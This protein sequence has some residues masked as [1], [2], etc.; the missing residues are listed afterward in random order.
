ML[1]LRQIMTHLSVMSAPQASAKTLM[2]KRQ[3]ILRK[4]QEDEN[5]AD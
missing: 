1:L 2:Q 4:K 5:V 3:V